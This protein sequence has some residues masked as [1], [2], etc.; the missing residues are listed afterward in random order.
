MTIKGKRVLI[1]EDDAAIARLLRDNLQ[2]DGFAVEW[3]QI[4]RDAIAIAK[5][6]GARPRAARL[7]ASERRGRL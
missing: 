5:R 7:D 4:G 3:S 2:F 1:V 6:F